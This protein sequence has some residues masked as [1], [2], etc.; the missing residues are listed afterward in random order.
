MQFQSIFSQNNLWNKALAIILISAMLLAATPILS[1]SADA[2]G[3]FSPT[4]A[5]SHGPG[6]SNP[7]Y[8]LLSDNL[9]ATATKNNRQLKL[10]NFYIPAISGGSIINGIEVTVEG[11]TTGMQAD[12]AVGATSFSTAK[13][14]TLSSGESVLTLGGP[15]DT[16]GRSWAAS[17]FT[18]KFTVKITVNGNGSTISIDQVRVKVYFTPPNTTLALA[19]V[20]GNYNGSTNMTAT[21]T[22][23]AT[24]A[25]LAG[26]TVSFSLNGIT[27]GSAITNASGLASLA[28]VSLAGINANDYPYGAAASFAGDGTNEA[29]ITADLRVYGLAS[30]LVMSPVSGVYSGTTGSVT[31]T[32]TETIAGTPIS[33][34]T[35]DFTLNDFLVGS[36]IT[37]SF[38]V[39]SISGVSLT[40]YDAGIYAGAFE[41]TF[42]GDANIE[43]SSG[44][45]NLTV[46]PIALTVTGGLVP[47]NK[48][49]DGNTVA[50]LTVGSPS[51]NGVVNP[52]NVTLN[53]AGAVGTFSDK[54]VGDNKTVQISGLTLEGTA[55]ANYTITQPTRQANIT[56]AVLTVTADN[57]SIAAGSP[58]PTFT[59]SYSGLTG[60]DTTTDID[61]PPTCNVPVPHAGAGTYAIVCSGGADNN[62]AF[63]YVSGTLTVSAVGNPPTDISLSK[64]DINE[65]L[66]VGTIVGTLS[67]TDADPGE[68]FT[69]AFCGG[70]N[71]ASF[72]IEGN[73]L[74]SAAVFNWLAKRNYSV[75]V[76]STDSNALGITKTF[77]ISINKTT[78]T[79]AD[80]PTNYWSWMFI[81]R[82]YSAGITGGCNSTPLQ[83][84]PETIVNRAQMAV[85]LEKG[86]HGSSYG[87]PAVGAGTGF[88]DV[89]ANYWAAAWIKQLAVDNITSGCGN[90]NYCPEQ[91]VTRAQMAVFLLKS[92][93]GASYSPPALGAGSGFGDVPNE[94]WAA[95]WIKQLA[96]E[97]ITSGCGPSTYCPETPVTRAQMAVFLVK[98]FNL[99]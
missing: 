99:P 17:D 70:T 21:L 31:A 4:K 53:T 85:F 94:Y 20:A 86:I 34:K 40:G 63:S 26:K 68:T 9:Y 60:S 47:A 81:E 14:T 27:V 42:A 50:T 74:K 87:P 58:D 38:G 84:C 65:N 67:T 45:N 36:A 3:F 78:A 80:V 77:V 6:W 64:S 25:P 90:G 39:A 49:Y 11:F 88:G 76:S 71:D 66:A 35:V 95:A 2:L 79:F 96:A 52:D 89:P 56:M 73:N 5:V 43:P 41:A 82:L 13:T 7:A 30:T 48:T 72:T 51:L 28:G 32:L 37:D 19:P 54:N 1:A 55:A 91:A 69:Y 92:K 16:W 57:Q 61:T 46:N 8:S 10:T 93:Y 18:N 24:Q 12:V 44:S 33:G 83:Y 97:G 59:F 22:V 75:C 29:T 15:N 23:T 98:T 62:Y